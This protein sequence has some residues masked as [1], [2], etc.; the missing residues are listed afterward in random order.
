MRRATRRQAR[1]APG[2]EVVSSSDQARAQTPNRPIVAAMLS[3]ARLAPVVAV[4]SG[5]MISGDIAGAHH[6]RPRAGR[7]NPHPCVSNPSSATRR[8]RAA[9]TISMFRSRRRWAPPGGRGSVTVGRR[10]RESAAARVLV[11]PAMSASMGRSRS[12]G[13]RR[14]RGSERA[15]SSSR[16]R[17]RW[18]SAALPH[19]DPARVGDDRTNEIGW[20]RALCQSGSTDRRRQSRPPFRFR[21]AT[22]G[23]GLFVDAET[24]ARE[25]SARRAQARRISVR[26]ALSGDGATTVQP[27]ILN[28]AANPALRG[29]RERRRLGRRAAC[30]R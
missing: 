9:S 14:A 17:A 24:R 8:H 16:R 30:S 23:L 6:T 29:G 13:C 4:A 22:S 7:L 27:P 20:E 12:R 2:L 18:R 26:L 21:A 25:G 10:R 19:P 5:D 3:A 15:G 28:R 1:L 11:L